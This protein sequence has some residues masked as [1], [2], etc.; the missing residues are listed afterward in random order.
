MSN[1]TI[2]AIMVAMLSLSGLSACAQSPPSSHAQSEASDPVMEEGARA[3]AAADAVAMAL[4]SE[5]GNKEQVPVTT[6]TMPEKAVGP[7]IAST[8]LQECILR[9]VDGIRSPPDMTRSR[10]EE[11]MRVKLE[12]DADFVGSWWYTGATYEKW[13]YTVKV[14]EK[15]EDDE[16]PRIDISFSAGD[17][18]ANQ[19]ATVCTYELEE[20]ARSLVDLGFTRHP[21]WK[22]PGAQLL[23]TR[24]T[25][26]TRFST[27]VKLRKYTKQIGNEESDFQY[28]VY[29]IHIS[30]GKSLDGE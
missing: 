18:D 9:F 28:C 20:F 6:E 4:G 27:T 3:A 24:E 21:G 2:F 15:R 8:L 16:L 17:V 12:Q 23:F 5:N 1:K 11:V 13:E 22:Q 26:G 10:L 7:P 14:N 25:T 19:Q 29:V 30:A